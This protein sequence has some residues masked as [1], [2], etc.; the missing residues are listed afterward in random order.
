MNMLIDFLLTVTGL[1]V[2][3][4]GLAVAVLALGVLCTMAMIVGARMHHAKHSALRYQAAGP[5]IHA[6]NERRRA[7][8]NVRLID[9]RS[10]KRRLADRP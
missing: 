7:G 2:I 8:L 9:H 5:V 3:L 1:R 6:D 4:N 10:I